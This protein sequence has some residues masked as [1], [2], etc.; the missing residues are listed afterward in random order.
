MDRA[1]RLATSRTGGRTTPRSSQN[2]GRQTPLRGCFRRRETTHPV[3]QLPEERG[4]SALSGP[5]AEQATFPTEVWM[6]YMTWACIQAP[7]NTSHQKTVVTSVVSILAKQPGESLEIPGSGIRPKQK[8]LGKHR[9][10]THLRILTVG[11][12]IAPERREMRRGIVGAELEFLSAPFPSL[13]CNPSPHQR[14]RDA[15]QHEAG[16][17]PGL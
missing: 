16:L 5:C 13:R 8:L 7:G 10:R 11:G 2:A 3:R 12:R 14:L 17:F 4:T 6:R 1:K 9:V 15:S